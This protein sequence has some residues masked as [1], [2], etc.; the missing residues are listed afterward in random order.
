MLMQC[1]G[2]PAHHE[3]VP[4]SSGAMGKSS[5]NL[6]F[7]SKYRLQ[8]WGFMFLLTSWAPGAPSAHPGSITTLGGRSAAW[9]QQV[10]ADLLQGM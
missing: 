5:F 7:Q 4:V 9:H 1:H 3:P 8:K 2:C 6:D 10:R